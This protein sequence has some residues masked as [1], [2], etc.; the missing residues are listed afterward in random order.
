[1]G[2]PTVLFQSESCVPALTFLQA[3]V[4]HH[5]AQDTS[6]TASISLRPSTAKQEQNLANICNSK[7]MSTQTQVLLESLGGIFHVYSN[8]CTKVVFSSQDMRGE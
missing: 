8:L 6:G 1:M 5:P 3:S 4:S 2:S 7:H